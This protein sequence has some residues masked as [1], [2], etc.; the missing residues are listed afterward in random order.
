MLTNMKFQGS[1]PSCACRDKDPG[2]NASELNK[3]LG[4]LC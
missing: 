2:R 3:P 1:G 4:R